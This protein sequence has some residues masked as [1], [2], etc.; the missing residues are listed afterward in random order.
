MTAPRLNR[1]VVLETPQVVP[2]GMGGHATAWV[3]Q[4]TLWA[5]IRPGAGRA[6]EGE[7]VALSQVPL[8]VTVRAAA[9]GSAARPR[10]SQ[11]FREGTRI[12]AILAVTERDPE[13]RYLLCAAREEV[14]A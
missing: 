3:A 11:R 5:E 2:D 7:E 14:P 1:R 9:P 8:R 10:P 13:G 6:A 12:F 4:G